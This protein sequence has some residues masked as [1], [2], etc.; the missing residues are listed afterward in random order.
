VSGFVRRSAR[1]VYRNPWLAFEA[2][3]I[4]HPNGRPGEHGVCRV[5]DA[6]AV[7]VLDGEDAILTAQPRYAVNRTV[8]EIVKGG[9]NPGEDA[10]G[11]ARRETREEV[12]AVAERWTALG[13]VHEI[14]SI[15]AATVNLFLARDCRFVDVEPEHVETIEIVRM[16]F[17]RAVAMALEGEIEDAISIVALLR[18]DHALREGR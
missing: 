6:S 10:L 9:A 14:P 4:V 3:E 17:R 8:L 18:A 12:G 1:E 13:G 5:P 15:V 2:H 16:P 7:V 11:C